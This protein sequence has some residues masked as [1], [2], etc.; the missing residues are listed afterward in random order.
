MNMNET[1]WVIRTVRKGA[2]VIHGDTYRLSDKW[3]PYDGRLDACA[4]CLAATG[5][6]MTTCLLFAC[7]VLR[8]RHRMQPWPS[9]V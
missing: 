5:E 9:C 4:L 8:R 1:I 3:L 6:W 2:V 7:G